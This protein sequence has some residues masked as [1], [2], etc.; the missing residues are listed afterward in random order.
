VEKL[1]EARRLL[2][3]ARSIDPHYARALAELSGTHLAA[4]F[5]PLDN[6]YLNAAALDR[7]HWLA[8]HAVRLDPNLPQAH[9]SLGDVLRMKQQHD[10]AI[11][12]FEQ[13]T[14]LNPNYTDW[15]F[16]TPAGLSWIG[17]AGISPM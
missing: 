13:A 8:S 5:H 7:A 10:A 12:T 17:P 4:W 16:A 15:R 1:Y 14:V 11:A 2:E 6:H 9:A 3:Q